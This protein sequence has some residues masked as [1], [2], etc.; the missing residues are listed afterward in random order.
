MIDIH[1]IGSRILVE[2]TPEKTETESG[3]ILSD[4]PSGKPSNGTVLAIG[5]KC[6]IVKDGDSILYLPT[7]GTKVN[8]LLILSEEEVLAII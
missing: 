4:T 6:S 3:I 7:A 1:P 5:D 8:D 2:P